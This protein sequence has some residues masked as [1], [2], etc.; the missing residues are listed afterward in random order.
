MRAD[1]GAMTGQSQRGRLLVARP[2][3]H[4]DEFDRTVILL[5][6]HG[7]AGA[8][9][10][11]LNRPM[12][13]DVSAVLPGWQPWVS[14]P[15]TLFRGGPV[16]LDT[17]LGLARVDE[18]TPAGQRVGPRLGLLNLDDEP[19]GS[20]G[21]ARIFVGYAGWSG[22]Q[23][24]GELEQDAWWLFDALPG[25]AFTDAPRLLWSQVV[26]RQGGDLAMLHLYPGDPRWN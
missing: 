18:R 14:P 3:L 6:E 26:R 22:G 20:T 19:D 4:G 5:L 24:E 11:V 13:V 8:F 7:D 16:G 25:D 23:L 15:G 2:R 17:A 1:D 21:Q 10:V 9:G 12:E